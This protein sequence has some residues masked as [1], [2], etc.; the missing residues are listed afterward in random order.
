M[1]EYLNENEKS[2]IKHIKDNGFFAIDATGEDYADAESLLNAG[3]LTKKKAI[4]WMGD[5]FIYY[6]SNDYKNTLRSK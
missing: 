3:F 5:D 1:I 2:I 4:S 6:L